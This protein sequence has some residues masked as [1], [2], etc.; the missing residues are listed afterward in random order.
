MGN[1]GVIWGNAREGVTCGQGQEETGTAV[2]ISAGP[3]GL[4]VPRT[5]VA[6]TGSGRAEVSTTN[7]DVNVHSAPPE[8][9]GTLVNSRSSR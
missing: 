6:P 8:A 3:A 5:R 7:R 4:K 1:S 9:R 2:P